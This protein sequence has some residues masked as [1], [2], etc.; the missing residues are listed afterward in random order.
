MNA[1]TH[2]YFKKLSHTWIHLNAPWGFKKINAVQTKLITFKKK[3]PSSLI[4]V[5]V[6]SAVPPPLQSKFRRHP[7]LHLSF[8]SGRSCQ[9]QYM[10]RILQC[11]Y[12]WPSALCESSPNCPPN[13]VTRASPQWAVIRDVF[14]Y[15]S[16]LPES[17]I[18]PLH[19]QQ[20]AGCQNE[21][22]TK[23]NTVLL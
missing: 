13:L 17:G 11:S 3:Q 12:Q 18:H 19:P 2:T 7:R 6:W 9:F 8:R 22:T 4:W 14:L 20:C 23:E 10:P 5:L 21:P 1:I 15:Y 16:E